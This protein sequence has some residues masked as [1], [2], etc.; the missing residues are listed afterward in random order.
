MT[1]LARG[2]LVGPDLLPRHVAQGHAQRRGA[3]RYDVDVLRKAQGRVQRAVEVTVFEL[4][5][6]GGSGVA[7]I[8]LR[9]K[10][11]EVEAGGVEG[12]ASCAPAVVVAGGAAGY[13]AGRWLV[14]P[15]FE[16]RPGANALPRADIERKS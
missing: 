3:A 11:E 16:T 7:G 14:S 10:R 13:A 4:D 8:A 1:Q 9:G 6:Y 2:H 5:R 15:W 12:L